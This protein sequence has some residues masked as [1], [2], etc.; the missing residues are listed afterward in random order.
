M[1]NAQPLPAEPWAPPG[2][3]AGYAIA[4]S[5]VLMIVAIVMHPQARHRH[6]SEVVAEI[7]RLAPMLAFMHGTVIAF[8]IVLLYGMCVYSLRRGLRRELVLGAVVVYAAGAGVLVLAAL[9][10]GFLVSDVARNYA[11]AS[12]E[13]L[14]DGAAILSACSAA[15]QVLTK[16]GV[17][18]FSVAIALWSADLVRD[19]ARARIVAIIGFAAAVISLVVLFGAGR[20]IVPLTLS[21]IVLAQGIWYIAVASLLVQERV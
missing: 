1:S 13:A 10:D 3:V 21:A 2:K 18:A 12:R 19:G 14:R 6:V 4:A 20:F 15:I 8:V 9:I 7:G 11:G 16:F 17:V 5:A